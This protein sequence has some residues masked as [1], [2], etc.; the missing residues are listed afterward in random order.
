MRVLKIFSRVYVG[1]IDLA[2]SF[3]EKLLNEKCVQRFKYAEMDLEL[4]NIGQLI[5]IAGSDSAL[6]QFRETSATFIV[7]SVT[8]VKNFILNEN[9]TVVRDI[10]TV[11]TGYNLTMRNADGSVIEYVQF[12]DQHL[13]TASG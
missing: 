6:Q 5:I 12:K 11:P 13:I 9:G 1:D 8:D 3:Y 10:R 7:D 2:I 4:A